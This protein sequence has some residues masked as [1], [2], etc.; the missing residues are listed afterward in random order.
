MVE[1]FKTNVRESEDAKYL[2]SLLCHHLPSARINIDLDDCDK[3]LR[4]E[5][6]AI[7]SDLILKIVNENGFVCETLS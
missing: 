4:V 2:V 6:K 7:C 1:V 5:G 3:V